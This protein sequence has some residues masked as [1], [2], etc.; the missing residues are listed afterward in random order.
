MVPIELKTMKRFLSPEIKKRSSSVLNKVLIVM[1]NASQNIAANQACK[2]TKLYA[3]SKDIL[4]EFKNYKLTEIE[5][6]FFE[7]AIAMLKFYIQH[8]NLRFLKI[9]IDETKVPYYGKLDNPFVSAEKIDGLHGTTGSYKY[10]TV[11]C[12]NT[13]CKLILANFLVR[14]DTDVSKLIPKVLDEISKIKPIKYA[15]FD[16]GFTN[17]ELVYRL[18]QM[19]I[20]YMI[21]WRKSGNWTNK[22]YEYME[23]EEM[24]FIE[25]GRKI[26]LWPELETVKFQCPFVFIKNYQY[27]KD[28][29]PHNW[30]FSTNLK[31]KEVGHCIATYKKRWGI[32]TIFRVLKQE[33]IIKTSSKHQSV[34]LFEMCFAMFF[35]NLWQCAKFIILSKIL[36]S[37]K[38]KRGKI[39]ANMF[40][41][42][43]RY[44]FKQ[45]F[46]L[47]CEF[48]DEILNFLGLKS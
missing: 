35:Y 20:N 29:M 1:A 16:R 19:K 45:K 27:E 10:L 44:G 33:F 6:M 7:M 21:F 25:F 15:L 22:I 11:S 28:S 40:M 39:H 41:S 4:K 18:I 17:L 12:V 2:K 14:P 46:N 5:N 13:N 42:T 3:E 48:E 24:R 34:R 23:D 31:I 43:L 38:K 26:Y 32:E 30:L 9:A 47:K 37:K 36:P 8:L